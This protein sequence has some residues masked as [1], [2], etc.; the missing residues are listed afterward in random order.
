MNILLTGMPA[1]GKTAAAQALKKLLDD[2]MLIDTDEEIVKREILSINDIFAKYGEEYFR[3]LETEV[4]KN[5]LKKDNQI[6]ASGGGIVKSDEN[7]SL[8]KQYSVSVYLKTDLETLYE[9]ALKSKERPLLNRGSLLKKLKT[10]FQER[11]LKYEQ[12]DIIINTKG[13]TPDKTA[14]EILDKIN[15]YNKCKN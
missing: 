4:L 7:M 3:K 11:S 1:S 10:L 14:E 5:T 2:Y 12:A 8:I 13:L 9:R 15:E 6:I